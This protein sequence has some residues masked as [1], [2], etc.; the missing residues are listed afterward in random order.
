MTLANKVAQFDL[1]S[2]LVN[3]WVHGPASGAG[4]TITTD[5]GPVRTPAKLI[6]DQDA[7]I[8]LAAEGVL[9]AATSYSEAALASLN[10]FRGRYY[11]ALAS[12]PTLDPLGAALTV[13]DMYL[14]IG[15]NRMRTYAGG[16]AWTAVGS[17]ATG[18]DSDQV[19]LETNKNVTTNYTISTGFNA[20]SAGPV[21]IDLGVT[22]TVPVGS[23]WTIV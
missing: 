9:A 13:G 4:S 19:F 12:N 5:S 23:V 3:A 15:T 1:D 17:A 7:A 6:A 20:V 21:S 2:D 8:N 14:H 10:D 16:G 22:V 11:G 18:G